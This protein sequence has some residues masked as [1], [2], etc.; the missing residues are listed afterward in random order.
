MQNLYLHLWPISTR[1]CMCIP[2]VV[3]Q[4]SPSKQNLK[5]NFA[6]PPYCFSIVVK[7]F[8]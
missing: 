4:L 6:R 5:T 7:K 2:D 1:N 3:C 8:P